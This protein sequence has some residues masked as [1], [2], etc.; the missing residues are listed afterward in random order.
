MDAAVHV[1]VEVQQSHLLLIAAVWSLHLWAT[2]G[3]AP[4]GV[5]KMMCMKMLHFEGGHLVEI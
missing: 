5:G 3:N 2:G 1:T 4:S